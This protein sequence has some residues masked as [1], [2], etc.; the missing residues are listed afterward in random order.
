METSGTDAGSGAIV[1]AFLYAGG[2]RILNPTRDVLEFKK[3]L[4]CEPPPG[5]RFSP[6]LR[7]AP[8]NRRLTFVE[9]Q[10]TVKPTAGLSFR[11]NWRYHT[12]FVAEDTF[13]RQSSSAYLYAYV[14]VFHVVVS[15]FTHHDFRRAE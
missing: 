10:P 8:G 3:S 6:L 7:D 2:H 11:T 12:G 5:S 9:V 4:F 15:V 14:F 13:H 1:V